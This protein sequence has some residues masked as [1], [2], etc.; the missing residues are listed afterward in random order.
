MIFLTNLNQDVKFLGTFSTFYNQGINMKKTLR[1]SAVLLLL[2]LTSA[3]ALFQ[4]SQEECMNTNWEQAGYADGAAGKL[5]R[6]L[7]QAV[8]DCAK[9]G[10]TVNQK[11]YH[12]GWKSGIRQFC[13][14]EQGYTIGNQGLPLPTV[15][16]EGSQK[17]FAAGW[18]KGSRGFCSNPSNAFQIGKSG[19]PFPAACSENSS[20]AFMSEFEHGQ[21]LFQRTQYLHEKISG[22]TATIEEKASQYHLRRIYDNFYKLGHDRSPQAVEALD[23]VNHLVQERNELER[24]INDIDAEG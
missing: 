5:P 18:A 16:P 6:S 15:C 21:R 23:H 13:T 12:Q 11:L 3:C 10:I 4:M 1:L 22:L 8:T 20:P 24:R 14:F 17:K 2:S 7:T 19:Q 9:Y